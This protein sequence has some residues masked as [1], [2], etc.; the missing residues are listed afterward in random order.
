MEDTLNDGRKAMMGGWVIGAG[1]FF[2]ATISVGVGG[3]DAMTVL[4][5]L[6]RKGKQG[7]KEGTRPVCMH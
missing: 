5:L 2:F 1:I 4:L 6:G 3:G 7:G